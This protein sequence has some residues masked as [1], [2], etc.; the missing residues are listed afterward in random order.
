MTE[1]FDAIDV[2]NEMHADP[3]KTEAPSE[4]EMATLLSRY[5]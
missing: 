2:F 1:F 5:G 4:D 3:N